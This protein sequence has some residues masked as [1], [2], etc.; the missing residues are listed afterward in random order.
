M[1]V[2]INKEAM[3]LRKRNWYFGKLSLLYYPDYVCFA[4]EW[5]RLHRKLRLI[6]KLSNG[7][8]DNPK[9]FWHYPNWKP[10][11]MQSHFILIMENVSVTDQDRADALN[12]YS[13]SVLSRKIL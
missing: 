13:S 4:Q 9:A 6:M 3:K 10:K 8:K 11:Y 12:L 1:S 7:I 2:Y 5:N